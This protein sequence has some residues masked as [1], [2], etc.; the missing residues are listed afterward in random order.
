MK[1]SPVLAQLSFFLSARL[2]EIDSGSESAADEPMGAGAR[3]L[4]DEMMPMYT[5]NSPT[6]F[7]PERPAAARGANEYIT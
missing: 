4:T 3:L 1:Y 7:E 2:S 6:S 5:M